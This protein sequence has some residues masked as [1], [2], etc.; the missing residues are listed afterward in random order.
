M[1]QNTSRLVYCT[2]RPNNAQAERF[3]RQLTYIQE[4]IH[5]KTENW[6]GRI[7]G[8][9]CSIPNR[10]GYDNVTHNR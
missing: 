8:Q 9:S 5:E 10:G 1:K 7:H 3:G 6:Q 2:Y 4:R